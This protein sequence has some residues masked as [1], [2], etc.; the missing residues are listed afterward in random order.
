MFPLKCRTLD[1]RAQRLFSTKGKSYEDID[2][3]LF[4]KTKGGIKN[5]TKD[6]DAEKQKDFAALEAQ[7]YR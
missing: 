6:K 4:A 7:V 3:T 1:E 5:P 2:P